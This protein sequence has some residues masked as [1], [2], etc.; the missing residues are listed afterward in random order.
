MHGHPKHTITLAGGAAG[1]A[2][3]LGRATGAVTWIDS[4]RAVVV[5]T[6]GDHSEVTT[7]DPETLEAIPFL[8]RVVDAIGDR[9]RI[10]IL[11]PDAMRVELE[12]EYVSIFHRPD[13]LL[14]VETSGTADEADLIRR[15]EALTAG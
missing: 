1:G 9:D 5:G 11:G 14:D 3:T 10:L 15:L 12:R 4:S 6:N 8:A 2:A 13:R 7:L